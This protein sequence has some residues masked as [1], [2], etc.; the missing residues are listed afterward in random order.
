VAK[1]GTERLLEERAA[2]NEIQRELGAVCGGAA[3]QP[4][5][6]WYAL[7]DAEFF[8]LINSLGY[9]LPVDL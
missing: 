1:F 7:E 9:A 5:C 6:R 4:L 3:L 8:P 2:F